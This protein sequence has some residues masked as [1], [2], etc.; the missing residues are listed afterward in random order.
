MIAIEN[1]SFFYS[2]DK[3][4]HFSDQTLAQ[5]DHCLLTG[6]SGS[7]KTT[8]MHLIAGFLKPQTGRVVVAANDLQSL[9]EKQRDRFRGA[10]IGLVF[11]KPHLLT[12]LTV[13]ENLFLAQYLAKL[14][15]DKQRVEQI[16]AELNLTTRKNAAV[17]QL[18]QGEAQRV[19]I[20]RA[21][22]NKP[23]VI[24]ADE[25]TSSLDDENCQKVFNLLAAQAQQYQATLLIATHDFRLKQIVSKQIHLS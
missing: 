8:L 23:K 4:L 12:A 24:L 15:Q 10:N 16:L 18:S 3:T 21:L 6:I 7:G 22:L 14:P 2:K 1:L 25:P 13:K 20:A 19:S 11:Q 5:G 9:S 17:W